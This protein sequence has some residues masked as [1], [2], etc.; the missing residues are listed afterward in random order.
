M[1]AASTSLMY[2]TSHVT[3]SLGPRA[4]RAVARPA[5]RRL[6]AVRA[7]ARTARQGPRAEGRSARRTSSI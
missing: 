2:L 4:A 7:V 3:R 1:K 5:R 6:R